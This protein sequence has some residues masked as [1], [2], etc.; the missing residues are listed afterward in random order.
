MF[1]FAALFVMGIAALLS[2]VFI[3]IFLIT[4]GVEKCLPRKIK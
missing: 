1:L 4:K 3:C 2:W